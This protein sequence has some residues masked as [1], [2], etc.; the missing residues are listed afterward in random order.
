M[1]KHT[2]TILRQQP[3]NCLRVFGHFVGLA[4][5]GLNLLIK[6]KA[7]G[8]LFEKILFFH[9]ELCFFS[10][11]F[12]APHPN[13]QRLGSE[14]TLLPKCSYLIGDH[15]FIRF[16]KFSEKTHS[17]HSDTHTYVCVSGGRKY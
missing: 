15:S 6:L 17:L 4:L 2:Q 7:S 10:L 1:V 11:V 12:T 14:Y 13:L 9:M 5:K 3:T 16:T 8:K